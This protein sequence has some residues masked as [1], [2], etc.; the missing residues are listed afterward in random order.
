MM[1]R[2]RTERCIRVNL[3]PSILS[4]WL[5]FYL[6]HQ[7]HGLNPSIG[8]PLK[9]PPHR[10]TRLDFAPN[11]HSSRQ[12]WLDSAVH[13]SLFRSQKGVPPP[14]RHESSTTARYMVLTTPESII[15]QASTQKLLDNLIDESVRTS[16][17]KPI[18]IQFD[19]SGSFVSM[20]KSVEPVDVS[21]RTY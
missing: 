17:R 13:S 3:G 11:T 20:P 14:R 21:R 1:K 7:A 9:R 12:V 4:L 5:A 19:P 18:M 10:R 6:A 8:S 16:P 2:S 15:E